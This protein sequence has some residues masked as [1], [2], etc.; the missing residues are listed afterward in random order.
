LAFA[1][2]TMFA[3]SSAGCSFAGDA[4]IELAGSTGSLGNGGDGDGDGDDGPATSTDEGETDGTDTGDPSDPSATETSPED[5]E[6]APDMCDTQAEHAITYSLEQ[7]QVEAAA[8]LV[9]TSVLAGDGH[10]PAIPLGPRPFLNH[11]EFDYPSAD[12]WDPQISGELWQS[13]MINI[14]APRRYHLQYAVRGPLMEP[15]LRLPVDLAIVVDLGPAMSGDPLSLAEEALAAVEASLLPGDRVTLIGAGESPI[16][17]ASVKVEAAGLTPL[18]GL[19][20]QQDAAA[21]SDVGAALELAYAEV[22]PAWEGQGQTR[23]LLISNG[24]FLAADTLATHVADQAA[25]DCYLVTVGVGDPKQFD[26]ARISELAQVGRGA[27]LFAPDA[28]QLWLD[29]HQD[30]SAN[31]LAAATDLEVTLVLPPGLTL[32]QRATSNEITPPD[33]PGLGILAP[34]DALVFHHELE[35]CGDLASDAVLR[36]HIEW[37]DPL[38]EVA[39]QA[40]WDQPVSALGQASYNGQK[41]A[42]TVAYARALRSFRDGLAPSENYGVLLDAISQISNALEAKPDDLDLIEMSSVIAALSNG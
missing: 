31:L 25:D 26:D 18:T 11:F 12:G 6:F 20:D 23:V 5:P 1:F 27:M 32:R 33:D 30:F 8:E 2:G 42:A 22:T 34:N 28:E 9:S 21:L 39:K 35:A 10:V 19:L 15:A 17:L 38:A 40:V 41:G 36:V 7:A 16:L 24:Q 37:T 13:S 3:L 14:D 4:S 29:L